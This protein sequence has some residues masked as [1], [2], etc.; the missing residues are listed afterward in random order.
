MNYTYKIIVGGDGAVG[1]T[2]LLHRFIEGKF[3]ENFQMTLGVEFFVK[4]IVKDNDLYRLSIWDLGG[5]RQFKN[6]A[7]IY[8][9]GFFGA[10]LAFDLTRYSTL[11][12]IHEWFSKLKS[13]LTVP[14]I[15][16]GTKY[17]LIS[18]EDAEL[19]ES[20]IETLIDEYKFIGYYNTSAKTGLNVE[21]VFKLLLDKIIEN[22]CK[23][24]S[25]IIR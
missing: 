18:K 4:D 7:E 2:T 24:E 13:D 22:E 16:I 21:N 6:L 25:S 3:R 15:L 23:I 17:D 14:F 9:K 1:K 5:Q 12:S 8:I 19:N 20:L 10:I 11:K